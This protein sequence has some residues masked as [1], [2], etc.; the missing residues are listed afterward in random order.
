MNFVIRE[1][2]MWFND[3]NFKPLS[4][5]FEENKINVITGD[6]TKGKSSVVQIIDYCLGANT[7]GISDDIEDKVSWFGIKLSVNNKDIAIARKSSNNRECYFNENGILPEEEPQKNQ[8]EI[9]KFLSAEFGLIPTSLTDFKITSTYR[10]FFAF[11][12]ISENLISNADELF[13]RKKYLIN[14]KNFLNVFYPAIG[15]NLLKTNELSDIDRE[16]KTIENKI[17]GLKSKISIYRKELYDLNSFCEN[18]RLKD[19]NSNLSIDDSD[20]LN[21]IEKLYNRVN[22]DVKSDSQ[23]QD[24]LIRRRN[25]L[26]LK[27]QTYERYKRE[28]KQSIKNAESVQDSLLPIEVLKEKYSEQIANFYDTKTFVDMLSESLSEI[29]QQ[30]TNIP[31]EIDISDYEEVIEQYKEELS[32]INNALK[33][34]NERWN[35]SSDKDKLIAFG[36]VK[37]RL[38]QLRLLIPDYL[39][40]QELQNSLKSLKEK[41]VRA[42]M[43][44]DEIENDK[45]YKLEQLNSELSFFASK[46]DYKSYKDVRLKF[47]PFKMELNLYSGN[48]FIGKWNSMA[49]QVFSKLSLF[50]GLHLHCLNINSQYVPSFLIIDQPCLPFGDTEDDKIQKDSIF[51]ILNEFIDIAKTINKSFQFIVLE[52]ADETYWKDKYHNFHTV[53]KFTN[54]NGLLPKELF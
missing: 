53:D 14:D 9:S 6:G 54:G 43:D 17:K 15:V 28:Y 24:E 42:K 19:V 8:Q 13:D 39:K 49:L 18:N 1:I 26:E 12:F 41:R 32:N 11:C 16:I 51:R 38:M 34:I 29:K 22:Q 4:Y 50:L 7:S 33:N 45:R 31:K 48:S 5:P 23:E 10:N 3:K 35:I 52:H 44:Y 47:A 36:Q 37:Y 30:M 25:F 20:V 27:I 40:Y 46:F 2:K 21:E